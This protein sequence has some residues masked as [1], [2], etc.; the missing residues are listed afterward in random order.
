HVLLLASF[1]DAQREE[2]ANGSRVEAFAP[3]ERI[4]H[5]GDE[6]HF[7]GVVLE[8]T[9][10]ASTTT[11]NGEPLALGRLQAGEA[12]G[13]L[14]LISCDRSVA[15]LTAET[16]CRVMLVPL[17]LFQS[18]IMAE[19]RAVQQISRTIGERLQHVMQD[20]AKAAAVLRKEDTTG[21]LQLKGERP[22]C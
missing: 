14:S 11:A 20:P 18:H 3:G 5:A 21:L 2:L 9:V 22:E 1:S 4:A 17:T 13:E 6:V 12:F 7:F 15:E 8:G 10:M 19:P 16:R